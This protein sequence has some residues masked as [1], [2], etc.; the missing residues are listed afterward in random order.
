MSSSKILIVDVDGTVAL[1]NGRK[2][3]EWQRIAED[4]PNHKVVDLINRVASTDVSIIF[5]SGREERY[6]DVT[7]EWLKKYVNFP[8]KLYCRADFDQRADEIIKLEIFKSELQEK[9]E[10]LAV[11]DDRDKVVKM[12]REKAGLVCLQVAEGDF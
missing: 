10:V 4:Q 12:W 6:R 9:Y 2:P 8:F 5:V 1:R 3:F 11:L 7:S